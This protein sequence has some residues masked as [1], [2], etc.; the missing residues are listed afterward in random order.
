M[1]FSCVNELRISG[2]EADE[3]LRALRLLL[4]GDWGCETPEAEEAVETGGAALRLGFPSVDAL[5]EEEIKRAAPEFP[6]LEF[7]LVYLSL[8]GEFCGSCRARGAEFREASIDLDEGAGAALECRSG[9]ELMGGI[10]GLLKDE[11]GSSL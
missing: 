4:A 8:D 11:P 2:G 6:D 3:R 7:L 1:A 10:L 9:D 5:V